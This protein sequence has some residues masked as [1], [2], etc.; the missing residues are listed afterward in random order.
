[1]TT[2]AKRLASYDPWPTSTIGTTLP[3][4]YVSN[5]SSRVEGYLEAEGRSGTNTDHAHI[6]RRL[7]NSVRVQIFHIV[8]LHLLQPS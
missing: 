2:D 3:L 1:M 5:A 8:F 6:H 7:S 4:L